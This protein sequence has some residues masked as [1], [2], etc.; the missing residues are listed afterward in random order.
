MTPVQINK[1]NVNI[2][3]GK[4]HMFTGLDLRSAAKNN[5]FISAVNIETEA[6]LILNKIRKYTI[7]SGKKLQKELTVQIIDSNQ[8]DHN[9]NI[10][11]K[12]DHL[13]GLTMLLSSI[14]LSLKQLSDYRQKAE[15]IIDIKDKNL[16]LTNE[17]KPVLD[18]LK[19]EI[20]S[21]EYF[22]KSK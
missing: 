18:D 21:I 7:P 22:I 20:T 1:D 14:H 17:V 11:Q 5:Q 9:L 3:T 8:A 12:K 13:L 15:N 19:K 10:A 16:F 4:D 6:D 2:L